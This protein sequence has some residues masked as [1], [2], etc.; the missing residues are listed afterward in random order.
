M[1][2]LI[3]F[4]SRNP[5][6]KS[7]FGSV[8]QDREMIFKIFVKDGVY[9]SDVELHIYEDGADIPY[10]FRMS[11]NCKRGDESEYIVKVN[12]NKVGL[13]WYRFLFKTENGEYQYRREGDD[14]Q[15]TVYD[16]R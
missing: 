1:K 13:Y 5:H 11:F 2:E 3:Y 15:F 7:P 16:K 9:V 4:D 12:I 6:C 10:V 8:E 14:F